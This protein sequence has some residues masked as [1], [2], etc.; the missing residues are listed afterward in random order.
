MVA[1]TAPDSDAGTVLPPSKSLSNPRG[2]WLNCLLFVVTVVSTTYWGRFHYTGFLANFD[3]PPPLGSWLTGTWYSFSILAI[4]GTHE[5]GHYYACRYYGINVSPPYFLP[6]PLWTGTFGAFIRI[7]EQIPTKVMLFDI[8]AAGPIAGFLVAV[9]MLFLGLHLSNVVPLPQTDIGLLSL[10][11][12]LLFQFAAWTVWGETPPG[13]AINLHPMG[14][15]AWFGLLAT[16]LNLFPIGQLDGGHIS[17]A[18][19]GSK[20]TS[21]T[22][23][24][25]VILIGL[26]FLSLSWLVWAILIAVGL[27]LFGHRHPKTRDDH[28]PLDYHRRLVAFATAVIFAVCFTPT[29]I[30]IGTVFS[31]R[32][33]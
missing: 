3:E 2:P 20:S 11:E 26:T 5:F 31:Q 16:A 28:I 30:E 12:P 17:Y 27:L 15:A 14:F 8:G 25:L 29:P 6:A 18:A 24:G 22:V 10:G 23:I 32:G 33:P 19:L 7:R 4:L 13:Y 21:V 1:R 9:P